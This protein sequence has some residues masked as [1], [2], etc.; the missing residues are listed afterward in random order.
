[1]KTVYNKKRVK[2]ESG[3]ITAETVLIL[4]MAI[5]FGAFLVTLLTGSHS[6]DGDNAWF[7]DWYFLRAIPMTPSGGSLY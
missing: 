7:Y 6:S 2:N 3:T 1:M 4:A 5:I